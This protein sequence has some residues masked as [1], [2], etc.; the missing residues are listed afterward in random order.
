M[1]SENISYFDM[2]GGFIGL[3]AIILSIFLGIKI[4]LKY[5]NNPKIE[6][7]TIGCVFIFITSGWWGASLSFLL[8][9]FFY[10]EISD[11]LYLILSYFLIPISLL[12]WIYTFSHLVYTDIKWRIVG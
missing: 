4:I 2:L 3:F 1:A 5:R 6:F 11:S 10:I 7:I 8:Y 12:F 9:F